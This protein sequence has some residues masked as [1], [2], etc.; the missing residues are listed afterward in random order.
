MGSATAA[1]LAE[2]IQR[3]LVAY[4]PATYPRLQRKTCAS[5]LFIH[6]ERLGVSVLAPTKD[7]K[8][9]TGAGGA[10]SCAAAA[11]ALGTGVACKK[12]SDQQQ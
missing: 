7:R 11:A 12:A 8:T 2:R 4:D 10:L 5:S 3:I 1:A 6:Q 9:C